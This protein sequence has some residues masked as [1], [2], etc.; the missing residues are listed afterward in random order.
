M[1]KNIAKKKK[2]R[3]RRMMRGRK[4]MW[5]VSLMKL[6]KIF[7]ILIKFMGEVEEKVAMTVADCV[8]VSFTRGEM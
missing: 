3:R 8:H 6:S 2:R 4:A 5:I 1:R 7:R